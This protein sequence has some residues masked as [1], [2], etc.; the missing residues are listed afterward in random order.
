MVWLDGKQQTI[1][2]FN[3]VPE[4]GGDTWQVQSLL[5]FYP[6][7]SV[8]PFVWHEIKLEVRSKENLRGKEIVDFGQGSAGFYRQ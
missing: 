4:Y 3:K 7:Q 1:V 6:D 5:Q 2:Q 8:Q